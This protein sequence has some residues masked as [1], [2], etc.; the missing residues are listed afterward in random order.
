M[1]RTLPGRTL[2]PSLT[3]W[4]GREVLAIEARPIKPGQVVRVQFETVDAAWRQGLWLATEGI[5]KTNG[6]QSSQILLWTD[7][8]SPA[9][10]IEVMSTRGLLHMY[11]VWD[12][13]RGISDFESQSATSGLVAEPVDQATIRYRCNDIGTEPDFTKLVFSIS[14]G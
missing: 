13:G 10:D 1:T 2:H 5:L 7:T 8:A 4:A 11:N 14:V 9:V 12:S 3:E 6:E